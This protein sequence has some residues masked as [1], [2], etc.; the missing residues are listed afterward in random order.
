M[1]LGRRIETF[2]K[3]TNMPPARFGREAAG[4]PRLVFD[5]RNGR[6]VGPRLASRVINFMSGLEQGQ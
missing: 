4:D 3:T 1:H 2:L 5:V 6:E